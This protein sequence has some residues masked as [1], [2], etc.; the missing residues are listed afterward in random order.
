MTQCLEIMN[1][2]KPGQVSFKVLGIP[3]CTQKGKVYSQAC[4][5]H[6]LQ[7]HG[8]QDLHSSTHK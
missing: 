2:R 4:P 8:G 7:H 1:C 3:W 5:S 6:K